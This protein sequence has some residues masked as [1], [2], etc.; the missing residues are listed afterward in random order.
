MRHLHNENVA[1]NGPVLKSGSG[2]VGRGC[3]KVNVQNEET[4]VTKFIFYL[5]TFL[6][7]LISV[8]S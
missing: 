7:S 1:T 3:C 2:P 8:K 6:F 4:R 5:Y